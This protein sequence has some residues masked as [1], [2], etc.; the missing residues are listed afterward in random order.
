M[1]SCTEA[2]L[3][4]TVSLLNKV[5]LMRNYFR[6]PTNA[7]DRTTEL[8]SEVFAFSS[9]NKVD[10]GKC[11]TR[12]RCAAALNLV[13]VPEPE[14]RQVF[15]ESLRLA[16][17]TLCLASLRGTPESLRFASP[18]IFV[19]RLLPQIFSHVPLWSVPQCDDPSFIISL[20][21]ARLL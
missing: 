6:A 8:M 13:S 2:S 21:Q 18:R 20:Q 1:Y 16:S 4:S 7:S 9:L 11:F 19:M 10:R 12:R 5:M 3:V 15:S 14:T 17:T